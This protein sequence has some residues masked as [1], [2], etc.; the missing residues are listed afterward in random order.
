MVRLW[1][2][3]RHDPRPVSELTPHLYDYAIISWKAD[4]KSM[5]IYL[6]SLMTVTT[7]AFHLMLLLIIIITQN[8]SSILPTCFASSLE[9]AFYITQNSSSE[10][11]I[12]LSATFIWTCRFNLLHYCPSIEGVSPIHLM[13]ILDSRRSHNC[14]KIFLQW[15]SL[16]FAGCYQKVWMSTFL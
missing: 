5:T 13:V 8:H 11:F 16:T 9:P 12:S 2:N 6:F 15:T 3:A 14:H 1:R 4:M 10:S 7:H